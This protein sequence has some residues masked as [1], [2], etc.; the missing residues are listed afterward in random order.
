M[1]LEK[2][3]NILRSD[4]DGEYIS[5]ELLH[6]WSQFDI[7]IQHLV[8]Y[9]PQQNGVAER[10][11]RSLKEMTTCMLESK[12]LA[13]N[14]WVEAMNAAAYIQNRVPHS[15]MK[16]KTPFEA[17][18]GHKPDVLNLRVFGCT[19]WAWIPLDKRRAL[20]PQ[21]I[22]CLFIR[23]PDESKGFKLLDIKTKQI[24]IERSVKFDEPLQEVELVKH[25]TVEFPSYS[26]E[27]LDDAIGGDD[28]DLDPII[29]DISV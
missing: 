23:Y 17:Y 29:S 15:S 18:F 10:N 25:K 8:P 27:Y 6:I 16:G 1:H 24:I 9:T 26:T 4:N 21:R 19:A 7:Q 20:Q 14:L 11:N 13:T 12:K 28:T 5:N 2:N 22:E 3:M